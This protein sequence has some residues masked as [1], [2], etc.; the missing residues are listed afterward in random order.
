MFSIFI[1]GIY[2]VNIYLTLEKKSCDLGPMIPS[3]NLK[4]SF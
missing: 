3:V 1:L 4:A 2:F